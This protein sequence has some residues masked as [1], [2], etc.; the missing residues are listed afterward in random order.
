M[1]T[2]DIN[3]KRKKMRNLAFY[4]N[5]L[6]EEVFVI[7]VDNMTLINRVAVGLGPYPVDKV[8]DDFVL[9]ITRKEES[10]TP[11]SLKTFSP[12]SK[13]NLQ[14]TPRSSSANKNGLILVS[15]ADMPLISVVDS[16]TWS[17]ISVY[18]ERVTGNI[19]DF[20]GQL[21]SGHERW[22]FDNDRFFLI[23]RVRRK[24]FLYKHST[25][26]LLWSINTPS[27]AH[28]ILP[29][30][31]NDDTYFIMC[32]GNPSIKLP[33]SVIRIIAVDDTF[34]VT[35]HQF[36]PIETND[37]D[38]SGGH[39]LDIWQDK[40]FVGSNE[41]YIYIF[42]KSNLFFVSKIKTGV[43]SGHTGFIN[44]ND[45]S[46]GISINHIDKYV[47]VFDANLMKPIKNIDIV[48]NLSGSKKTQGHT[49]GKIGK[50]F[51][52]MNSIESK[53]IE[54]DIETCAITRTLMLPPKNDINTIPYP[55]QGTF[56][57]LNINL[58][59]DDINCTQCC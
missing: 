34:E 18:G 12:L 8:N 2:N 59:Y 15:G 49:T 31:N 5:S 29:G 20:G 9:A 39:H 25:T 13:V 37:L 35:Q 28:H 53:F 56:I 45:L 38:N 46:T 14:H 55:M 27:A 17:V 3:L 26:E 11:I 4:G 52:V 50:F 43:G 22:L 57:S 7:D 42:D 44:Y 58:A 23:D 30:N 6:G 47:T 41:G 1:F 36:L 33:P 40:I 21:A 32:E 10:V 24:I 51:Y 19:A 54:I 16:K 48:S